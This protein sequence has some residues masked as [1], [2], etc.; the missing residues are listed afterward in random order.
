M[1]RDISIFVSAG[2]AS[3]DLHGAGLVRALFRQAPGARIS[4]LGGRNLHE[5]GAALVVDNREVAVVGGFEVARHLKSLMRAWRVIDRHLASQRPNLAVFIDFPDF[6][7]LLAR[8]AR[9]FGCKVFYYISPQ[10]WAWR[11]GRVRTLRRLVDRMAVILPFESE[12]YAAQGMKVHYVGHPLMDV[13]G[14]APSYLEACG[15]HRP[16]GTELL[17]GLLPGSRSGEVRMLLPILLQAAA[18]IKASLPGVSFVLP[19]APTL[20]TRDL[21]KQVQTGESGGVPVRLVEGDTWG[22]IRA[23]DLVLTASGTVTLETAILGTPM[24]ILYRISKLSEPIARLLIRTPF[25]GLPNLIAGR[26]ISPELIQDAANPQSLA[27]TAVFLLKDAR[28]LEQ[29]RQELAAI[30]ALLGRSGAAE[31][32]ARL[33]LELVGL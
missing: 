14:R 20:T 6:N 11:R 2:E 27:D 25:I 5:A 4:C 12:F 21:E 26:A 30:R 1:P 13:V 29:Q 18:R 9:R 3:G 15:R 31:R 22:V 32:A 7:L 10:V 24:V 33:A 19:V 28:R 17:V 16:S 23:C 8:K